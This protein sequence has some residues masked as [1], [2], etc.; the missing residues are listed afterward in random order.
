LFKKKEKK[1]YQDKFDNK[2][3]MQHLAKLIVV[4]EHTWQNIHL[5]KHKIAKKTKK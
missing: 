1:S 4:K 3:M 5:Q 2:Q